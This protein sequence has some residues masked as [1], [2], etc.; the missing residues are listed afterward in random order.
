MKWCL[1]LSLLLLVTSVSA[2]AE[3]VEF[4]DEELARDSVLPVFQNSRDVLHRH[5]KTVKRIE[6]GVGG[7]LEIDEPFYNDIVYNVHGG[8]H[9]SD[10]SAV[11]VDVPI[12]STGLSS[13]GQN[14][15]STGGLINHFDASK[16]PHP[17]WGLVGNYEFT[18]YYGKISI[19]KQTVM[20]LNLFAFAGP[21]Y[22]NMKT[23]NAFGADIGIG[24]NFFISQN[25]AI[26]FTMAMLIFEGP[27][28]A[29][30]DL[31]SNPAVN[32][33]P[34]ASD[35]PNKIFYNNQMMLSLVFLL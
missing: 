29:A 1:H 5:I 14:L 24:Q 31:S 35:F 19:T 20:N 22:I 2:R 18:A 16:A 9:W 15:Q 23:Y 21:L 12:W 17:A 34:A 13:Y 30:I 10:L 28:A 11:T 25:M 8:Y 6:V 7:G 32:Q 27:N 26:R 33:K 3:E 4:P